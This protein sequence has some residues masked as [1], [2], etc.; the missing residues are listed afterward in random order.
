MKKLDQKHRYA[1][2]ALTCDAGRWHEVPGY[3]C[4]APAIAIFVS[5]NDGRMRHVCG[6]H[7][8]VLARS[9][10]WRGVV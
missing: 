10:W 1:K 9:P 2:K 7:A 4:S 3:G 6:T 5:T 8:R